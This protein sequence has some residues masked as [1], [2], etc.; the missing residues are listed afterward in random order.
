MAGRKAKRGGTVSH[1]QTKV[2]R[3]RPHTSNTSQ[4]RKR[5]GGY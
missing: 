1:D 3:S 5:I 2:V 4:S